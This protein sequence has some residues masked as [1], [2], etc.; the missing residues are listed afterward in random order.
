MKTYKTIETKNLKDVVKSNIESIRDKFSY[1]NT[2]KNRS[3][4]KEASI[5]EKDGSCRLYIPRDSYETA[6]YIN[7]NTGEIFISRD[8]NY[9][10]FDKVIEF[11]ESLVERDEPAPAPAVSTSS[12]ASTTEAQ[13]RVENAS[14]IASRIYWHLVEEGSER[15]RKTWAKAMK[16]AYAQ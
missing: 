15:S 8:G 6:G 3:Y 4:I 14:T 11:I 10:I 2:F 9:S 7:L 13:E 16:M 12:S 1:T 5:W